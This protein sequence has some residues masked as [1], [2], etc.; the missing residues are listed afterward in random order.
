MYSNEFIYSAV[1]NTDIIQTAGKKSAIE[2]KH[3]SE[4]KSNSRLAE[5]HACQRS[6][7]MSAPAQDTLFSL[8]ATPPLEFLR[9]KQAQA[10]L[11]YA[12]PR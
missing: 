4:P 7:G 10:E 8:A 9:G 12:I 5:P 3:N 1:G 2:V 11:Y 6:A